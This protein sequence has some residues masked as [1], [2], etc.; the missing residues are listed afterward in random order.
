MQHS[1]LLRTGNIVPSRL[2]SSTSKTPS[3]QPLCID[4]VG[5]RVH[6][7]KNID[8]QLPLKKLICITGVSG[9]GK[10][11]LAFDTL[12]AE[13]QRRY[14]ETFS[15]Y[16]RQFLH[17]MQKPD[18]DSIEHIPPAI[19]VKQDASRQTSRSTI[20]T[21]T[22][23]YD[24]LRLLFAKTGQ[25]FCPTC[26]TEVRSQSPT[27]V[28]DYLKQFAS[29][30]RFQI[31]FPYSI[32][33]AESPADAIDWLKQ[34][35]FSRAIIDGKTVNL[36]DNF[37]PMTITNTNELWIVVDRLVAGKTE[38]GR[39]L[40]SLEL[41]FREGDG[42]LIVF[43]QNPHT[44][45]D[46]SAN[47]FEIDGK[48]WFV[49]TFNSR[50]ICG[51]CEREFSTPE[52][53]LFS[54]NTSVGACQECQGFGATSTI[55]F[56]R[57]VPDPEKTLRAGAIAA[58]TTPAY[59]HELHELLDLADAYQIPVDIPFSELQQHD[60]E[61]I[62]VG[63]PERNFGGLNGFFRWLEKN[64]YKKSVGVFLSRWRSYE[65]CPGCNGSRLSPDALAVKIF[66]KN[67]GEVCS[68]TI[69]ENSHFFDQFT[70]S[71]PEKQ[72]Q[73][74]S[75]IL[76]EITSR[77]DYLNSVGLGYLQLS[78]TM[79]TLST[80][81]ARRVFLT[82]AL[83]TQLVNT[84]Y[85]LDEPSTGL[86][87]RDTRNVITAIE[88]L[89]KLGNT[90]IVVEHETEFLKSV[91][92]VIDMG[93]GAGQ[94]GGQIVFAGTPNDLLT[95]ENSITGNYYSGRK[96]IS[97]L[98]SENTPQSAEAEKLIL[99]GAKQ[100]NLKNI[101]VEFPL[102]KLCVVTGVSGSGKSSLVQDT[103][104]PALCKQLGIAC[105]NDIFGSHDSLLG[106]QFVEDVQLVDQS[107]IGKSP[108]SMPA[109]Y[110]NAFDDIRKLF[111]ETAEART[112][113]YTP[114]HFSFNSA[115]GG[116]CGECT[117]NGFI[118]IDMQFLA[119]VSMTCPECNG[120]RFRPEILEVKYRGL[121]IA[122]VL[123]Q[124]V[125]EAFTF[126]RGQHKLQKRLNAFKEVGLDYLQLGQPAG[127]LSG[128]ESQRLKLAS[129]LAARSTK[130]TLF[131]L[132]EPTTGLHSADVE[133]LLGCFEQLLSVGHSLIVIEHQL[134]VINS[135][136]HI[137]DI[138]PEAGDAGGQVVAVGTPNEIAATDNSITGQFLKASRG[139]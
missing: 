61:L 24:F 109:T 80:G 28:L 91:E 131:I 26:K 4:V 136:D 50:L 71:L 8:V 138:G 70:D 93:P 104:Y 123:S 51:T 90:V 17:Q 6:N 76:P 125:G 14:I 118:K 39:I 46:E 134:D 10:S 120:S 59:V 58:W 73:F 16:A 29:G 117:G 18:V 49:S 12:F 105:S 22:E 124:T 1:F 25:V 114:G 48:V 77:L 7:L 127:T 3:S 86:H 35:G 42:R 66:D 60:L 95:A 139:C 54:F 23:I 9:S 5:A 106:A 44:T 32:D 100:H 128:G 20:G 97:A 62:T 67:I 130:K 112:R 72:A 129:A 64:R 132:D 83:G 41:A 98:N 45:E 69:A 85:V 65:T 92:W 74:C 101:T 57:L 121:N 103:L 38:D 115:K 63:V 13:G 55:S 75:S 19:A 99:S 2:N 89:H 108:R 30:T 36:L 116:R 53:S 81:E 68:S 107:P 96:Q 122:E 37:D 21:T 110:L 47:L 113:N 126:F 135:A 11:S 31:A 133:K 119:D 87:A 111:A 88:K 78:R 34:E 43:S 52:P 84:L 94:Q 102:Q 56:D 27:S 137:I 15:A 40:D 82:A 33:A 79:R